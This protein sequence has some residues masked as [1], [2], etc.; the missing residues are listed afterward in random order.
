[1]RESVTTFAR[2]AAPTG[3]GRGRDAMSPRPSRPPCGKPISTV[4]D[5]AD[6][7]LPPPPTRP[8][9]MSPADRRL[10]AAGYVQTPSCLTAGTGQMPRDVL[11]RRGSDPAAARAPHRCVMRARVAG[12]WVG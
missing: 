7:A 10:V 8:G 2:V 5:A 11:R 6:G 12:V 1:M 4:D 9:G 3:P